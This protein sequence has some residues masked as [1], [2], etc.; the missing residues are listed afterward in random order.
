MTDVGFSKATALDA[1]ESL[2]GMTDNED[3]IMAADAAARREHVSSKIEAHQAAADQAEK[4][5]A[6]LSILKKR[7]HS[8]DAKLHAAFERE[9]CPKSKFNLGV[10][11]GAP[12]EEL[13]ELK[14]KGGDANFF[15]LGKGL[16]S[17]LLAAVNN[18]D[19]AAVRVLLDMGADVHTANGKSWAAAYAGV[20]TRNLEVLQPLVEA[21]ADV[22]KAGKRGT[23]LYAAI[24][25]GDIDMVEWL[26]DQDDVYGV[27]DMDPADLDELAN[28]SNACVE[29]LE[30]AQE[31]A[32]GGDG[33][34]NVHELR[35]RLTWVKNKLRDT[36][37]QLREANKRLRNAAVTSTAVALATAAPAPAP[38]AL[39]EDALDKALASVL[40][41]AAQR[42][43][44]VDA[45][46]GNK[47]AALVQAALDAQLEAKAHQDRLA[48]AVHQVFP[49]R[50]D[51]VAARE[52]SA[53]QTAQRAAKQFAKRGRE[54]EQEAAAGAVAV[55]GAAAAAPANPPE[56]GE[57]GGGGLGDGLGDDL[58]A[59]VWR[60]KQPPG[61]LYLALDGDNYLMSVFTTREQADKRLA[62][63]DGGI[64]IKMTVGKTTNVDEEEASRPKKKKAK[65]S[66]PMPPWGVAR[67]AQ[68]LAK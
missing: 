31:H 65:L 38:E 16:P 7:Y 42:A 15:N 37:A 66:P 22:N 48:A 35:H 51:Y 45:R 58:G 13:Q 41:D 25:N 63:Y 46:G 54:D 19:A 28:G 52:E 39:N 68:Y 47:L 4:S 60:C 2:E 43:A 11:L 8:F 57:M 44:R 64:V 23:P 9:T 29:C 27:D 6:P 33:P 55:A 53:L 62:T 21:G 24:R 20:M 61:P 14:A 40:P 36:E 34:G 18:C 50:E 1:D 5:P 3:A 32:S 30:L 10:V 49:N 12:V 26:L 67:Y 56:S 59:L 17:P